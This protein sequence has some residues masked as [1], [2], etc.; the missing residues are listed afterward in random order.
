[1]LITYVRSSSYNN[2]DYCQL[3]YYLTYVLGYRSPS[4]KKAQLGTIIHKVMEILAVC[5]KEVQDNEAKSLTIVDDKVG[6][7]NFSRTKLKTK[8]FVNELIDR[9]F[10][11]YTE[12]CGHSYTNADKNFCIKNTFVALE[13][14]D[15]QFDPRKRNIVQAEPTFDITIDEPWAKFEYALPDGTKAE[16]QLAI[17]GTIDLVTEVSPGVIE[18]VDWKGLPLNTKLPTPNGWTTMGEIEI[19]NEVFDQYGQVCSVVGKSKVK[20]KPC[21]KIVFDDTTSAICDD[22]HLWKL[23]NDKTVPVQE[24]RIGDTINVARPI[25]CGYVDLPVSPYLLGCWL[26]D[27]RNRQ[28]EICSDD[29]ELYALL[30][31]DGH[32]IGGNIGGTG[33]A[34][35]RTVLNTTGKLRELNV[36]HNKHIPE[37]YFRASFDQRLDLLRGLLDTDGNANIARKQVAFTSCNEQLA[38]DVRHLALT[39][40]QRPYI[41]KQTRKTNF[42]NGKDVEVYHVSFRPIDINPFRLDRK[43]SRLDENWGPGRSK[44]RKIVS[45]TKEPIQKTQCISVNSPDNTYLC[46][47][48]YIPTHNTGQ[49][50]DWATGEEKTYEKLLE[51]PQLLLYNY[52]ISKLYSKDY[53]QAIMSIY[54]IR[55]G[56]PF[57]MCFDESDQE[58]FLGMLEKRFKQI[59]SSEWPQPCSRNRKSFK[60]TRLCHFYKTN[61]PGTNVSMCQHTEDHLQAFGMEETTK[62]LTRPGHSVGYYEAP[63]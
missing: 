52:A 27:G 55:D 41:Y 1:M 18:V 61:W 2:W 58:K 24:L 13:F 49:R 34:E 43:A 33:R 39:L 35:S 47:E 62:R 5:Q 56:G 51:D 4:G 25:D 22:E 36:L 46:T 60:C 45:I 21:Y 6:E 8:K 10:D 53:D 28:C 20:N 40:G 37:I 59:Q 32:E 30:E 48:N 7:V 9:S 54:Y 29:P 16:G 50:K 63:G 31:T 42:S 44:V 14:R 15:G 38:N 19:G 11:H 17:K 3:Q 26:G 12:S 23:A 57:S